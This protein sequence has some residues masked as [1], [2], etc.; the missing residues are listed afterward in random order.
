MKKKMA[1]LGAVACIL[2]AET[3]WALDDPPVKPTYT[4]PNFER[5][6]PP[7]GVPPGDRPD[8]KRQRF[9]VSQPW[10]LFCKFERGTWKGKYNPIVLTTMFSTRVDPSLY[11]AGAKVCRA[12]S[13]SRDLAVGCKNN[14]GNVHVAADIVLSAAEMQVARSFCYKVLSAL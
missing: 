3:A 14:R 6:V 11:P 10:D 4:R 9:Q 7:P 5:P 2:A 12:L 1:I 13:P 8:P